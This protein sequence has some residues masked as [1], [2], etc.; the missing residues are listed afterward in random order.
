MMEN[1]REDRQFSL[2]MCLIF[3][4]A[5]ALLIVR[6][7]MWRDEIQAWLLVRDVGSFWEL[8]S[9]L[10][11]ELHPFLWYTLLYPLK[12][13]TRNPEI[14]KPLHLLIASTTVFFFC[15]NAPFSRL[16]KLLFIFGYFP[17]FEYGIIARDYSLILLFSVLLALMYTSELVSP[18]NSKTRLYGITAILF[19]I[20]Q[21]HLFG[22]IMGGIFAF[23][24]ARD[25]FLRGERRKLLPL[26][27][28]LVGVSIFIVQILPPTNY[29]TSSFG[30]GHNVLR[31]QLALLS[32]WRGFFPFPVPFLHFWNTNIL[33]ISQFL[34]Y[35]QHLLAIFVLL[36]SIAFVL[37]LRELR[38]TLFYTVGSFSILCAIYVT[39]VLGIRFPGFIF[40]IFILAL[41]IGYGSKGSVCRSKVIS[42]L[43]LIHVAATSVA[44]YYD[45]KYPFSAAKQTARLITDLRLRDPIIV[46][47]EDV[48][49][50]PVAGYLNAQI[51]YPQANSFGSFIT[52][53]K[54]SLV[55]LT[56]CEIIGR[57][58]EMKTRT[59]RPVVVVF[60]YMPKEEKCM[61]F[62]GYSF[63]LV[64]YFSTAIVANEVY[65]IW[66]IQ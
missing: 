63:S 14:M 50:S 52:W 45:M 42:L 53:D 21:T 41:W 10:K 33:D 61:H 37:T 64:G 4:A 49:T 38:P 7:E 40:I 51:Y 58:V 26:L 65:S 12:F 32:V 24:L 29:F 11:N 60:N 3:V 6:H 44:Y 19:L 36:G 18:T 47:Y 34:Y 31:I 2:F 20:C 54:T 43:L 13:V 1:H 59:K 48:L 27:G 35:S 16:N 9:R 23:L 8:L 46:G 62:S 39:G 66:I 17:F 30:F 5:A 57:A 56:T 55:K 25:A 28:F 22:I 15:R